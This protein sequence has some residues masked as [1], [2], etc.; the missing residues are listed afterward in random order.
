MYSVVKCAT[1]PTDRLNDTRFLRYNCSDS[2]YSDGV[3]CSLFCDL[4]L[5]LVGARI[6]TCERDGTSGVGI[7]KWNFGEEPYCNGTY[8]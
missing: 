8:I 3:Q 2:T 7:W 6:L 4:N 1:G 5:D